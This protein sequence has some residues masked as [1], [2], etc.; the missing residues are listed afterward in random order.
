MQFGSARQLGDDYADPLVAGTPHHLIA[1]D[2]RRQVSAQVATEHLA[3]EFAFQ[4]LDF[5]LHAEVRDH[6]ARLFGTQ[7]AAP[8]RFHGGG[9]TFGGACGARSP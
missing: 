7:V 1:G 3:C 2:Q 8:E 4:C 9:F 6:Q 5:D